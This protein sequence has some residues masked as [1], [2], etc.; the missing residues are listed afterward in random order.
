MGIECTPPKPLKVEGKTRDFNTWKKMIEG[1][2]RPG[3]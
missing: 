3:V 2:V 1:N